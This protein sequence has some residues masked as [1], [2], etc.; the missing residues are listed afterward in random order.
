[1]V[2]HSIPAT[3][4]APAVARAA[5]V[6]AIPPALTD[7]LDDVELVLTEVVTN[8]VKHGS[9]DRQDEVRLAIE[10]DEDRLYV[11]VE[12]S[13]PAL[14]VAPRIRTR[15]PRLRSDPGSSS[16]RHWPTRGASNRGRRAEYGSRSSPSTSPRPCAI[17]GA[18]DGTR[19]RDSARFACALDRHLRRSLFGRSGGGDRSSCRRQRRSGGRGGPRSGR[20]GGRSDRQ[21]G[22][23]APELPAQALRTLGLKPLPERT[24]R[25]RR[26]RDSS[27][28]R[29]P[30]PRR[31][32]CQRCPNPSG[33]WPNGVGD[34]T[35][36]GKLRPA[37]SWKRAGG[38]D[39]PALFYF[40][41]TRP[42]PRGTREC[43]SCGCRRA[44]S[45]ASCSVRNHRR[46][47]EDT[48]RTTSGRPVAA[49]IP[50]A[51]SP[52]MKGPTRWSGSGLPYR[53]TQIGWCRRSSG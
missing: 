17:I 19:S 49:P 40:V 8:A 29:G 50:S 12:Q 32:R 53:S 25:Q 36:H 5:V 13:L 24:A 52:S 31:C 11:E 43:S 2:R 4:R 9:R 18:H 41:S 6:D 15:V 14:H 30:W 48:P 45:I 27:S 10:A 51:M 35:A 26:Q 16:S 3:P 21:P 20:P 38:S 47:Y 7:R 46:D 44:A 23:L 1:M 34:R 28:C 42:Q 37:G 22:R 39:A 33:Q